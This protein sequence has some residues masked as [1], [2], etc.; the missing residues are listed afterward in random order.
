MR[1]PAVTTLPIREPPAHRTRARLRISLTPARQSGDDSEMRA[2]VRRDQQVRYESTWVDPV[3]QPGDVMLRPR[4]VILT[5]EDALISAGQFG[6]EGVLGGSFVGMI[7]TADDSFPG[8]PGK[9]ARVVGARMTSCGTCELCRSGLRVH[10]RERTVLG[11]HGRH[12]CLAERIAM[13]S[14]S[15]TNVPDEIDDDRAAFASHVAAALQTARQVTVEAKPYITVLGDTLTGLLAAQIL[16]KMNAAVRVVGWHE[17]NLA[18]CERWSIKHRS[19]ADV[20]R[21]GDQDVIVECT[22][23]ADGLAEA[24]RMVRPRG[25][26]ILRSLGS[27]AMTE[28]F[29][30]SSVVLN[31]VRMR[32]CWAGNPAEGLAAIA[33][34]DVDVL[35]LITR[36]M[37]L[38][39]GVGILN[40]TR[41]PGVIGVMVDI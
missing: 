12:G 23:S 3:A 22:G 35:P 4:R 41:A 24:L 17:R 13:P 7:E 27:L 2:L 16:A 21:R 30:M 38:D 9:N 28:S 36:R 25:M 29:D 1:A 40:A 5:A 37:R 15:I 39:D 34:Q 31:E 14:S 10:C 33:R 32:G 20:G 11:L 18:I 8:L 26:V 6:F 19:I